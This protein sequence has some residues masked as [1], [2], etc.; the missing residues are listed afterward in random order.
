MMIK[1]NEKYFRRGVDR[2]KEKNWKG[3]GGDDEVLIEDD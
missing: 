1:Q 3:G 2:I